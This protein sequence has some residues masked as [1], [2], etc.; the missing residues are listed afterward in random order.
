MTKALHG[1]AMHCGRTR[2]M[3]VVPNSFR[4]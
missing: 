1:G 3:T 2:P 4:Q